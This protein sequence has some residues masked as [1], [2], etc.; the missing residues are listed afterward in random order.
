[1]QLQHQLRQQIPNLQSH[2]MNHPPT[3]LNAMLAQ[4]MGYMQMTGFAMLF[5]GKFIC[6][7]MKIE[8]PAIVTWASNNKMNSFCLLFM[9]SIVSSQFM[10]T[11]AFEVYYNGHILYSKLE[12]GTV[13]HVQDIIRSLQ[14]F[15][16][17]PIK[18]QF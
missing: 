6:E 4:L 7:M 16:V 5:A 12:R 15:G 9:M 10:A 8:E 13:P 11:G 17:Q 1:M 14:L 2:G 3:E 18:A